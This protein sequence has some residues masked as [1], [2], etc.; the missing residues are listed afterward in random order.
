[1]TFT[2]Y[3]VFDQTLQ[4]LLGLANSF[5]LPDDGDQFLLGVIWRREDD[6]GP[7]PVPHAAN[8]GPAAADQELVVLR[9]G[10]ELGSEVVDLLKREGLFSVTS[11]FIKP[12]S[13]LPHPPSLQP[14]AAA[15]SWPSPPRRQA[16]GW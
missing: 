13:A 11:S 14:A 9:F 7:R 15:V 6:A 1:M 16:L 8:I 5:L 10:L 2:D 4:L 12:L 3:Q